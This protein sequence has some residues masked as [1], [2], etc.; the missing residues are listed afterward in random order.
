[1]TIRSLMPPILVL[2]A[3]MAIGC[4]SSDTQTTGGGDTGSLSLQLELSNGAEI[5]RV[6]WAITRPGMEV[7]DGLIDTSAP[8]AT[9]SIEVYGLEPGGGYE[10]DMTAEAT[11]GTFCRGVAPFSITANT[12]EEVMVMLNCKS[13][14]TLGSV[15]ANGEFNI[16]AELTKVVVSPLQTSVG[17]QIDLFATAEDAE[18]DDINFLW[19]A[20]GGVVADN[21]ASETTFTCGSSGAGSVTVTVSDDLFDVCDH[22]W[23][24]PVECVPIDPDVAC[25]EG[26]CADDDDL[27]EKCVDVVTACFEAEEVNEGECLLAGLLICRDPGG[28]LPGET[29]SLRVAHLAPEIPTADDTAVDIFVDGERSPIQGLTF[30]MATPFIELPAGS[31]E[32]GIAPAGGQPI[33]TFPATLSEGSITTVVAIRTDVSTEGE[34]PVNVLAFDGDVSGLDEGEG[35][36]SIGHGLDEPAAAVVDGVDTNNCPPAIFPSLAFGTT[37]GPEPFDVGVYSGAL[38]APDSCEAVPPTNPVAVP[39]FESTATLVIAIDTDVAA[40]SI[41]PAAYGLVGNTSGEI[42]T[43]PAATGSD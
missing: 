16:C 13:P 43:L 38:A 3:L 15:R 31:Y 23:T 42:P 10:I 18:L 39:V 5:N 2:S 7:M 41:T 6:E 19:T 37:Q 30:A 8:G 27:K 11:D 4:S 1:M 29:A 32:F 40:N 9:A 35:G 26:F 20:D 36:I 28:E 25:D 14:T 17:S 12:A 33:F 24:V 34:S 21:T 22:S